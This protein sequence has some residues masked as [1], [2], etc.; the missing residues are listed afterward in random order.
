MDSPTETGLGA[1][2]GAIAIKIVERL[3]RMKKRSMDD[4]TAIRKELRDAIEKQ[5]QKITGLYA[6]L[7]EWREKYY[8]LLATNAEL[9]VECVSMRGEIADLKA[10]AQ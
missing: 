7:D 10:R 4:S 3:F 9:K 2:A 8:K 5:D 1:V 6:E